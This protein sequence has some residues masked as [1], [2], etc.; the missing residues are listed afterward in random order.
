MCAGGT[1]ANMSAP[2]AQLV[3]AVVHFPVGGGRVLRA[4]DGVDLAIPEGAA[5]GLVGES[6]SGKST[7]GRALLGLQPLTSGQVRFAGA[8]VAGLRAASLRRI[9]RQMQPVFQDPRASLDPRLTVAASIAEPLRTHRLA[10]RAGVGRRVAELLITVGLDESHGARRPGRLS[11]G[12]LQRVAIA[13]ALA[14][15]PRLLVLD[16]PISALDVSVAAQILNLLADI[17]RERGLGYLLIAHDLPAV[18]HV[19]DTVVVLYLGR[20]VEQGPAA[21]VLDAPRHPYTRALVASVPRPPG[22]A[23]VD[24]LRLTGEP[25]SPIAPPPGCPLHPR[26]P[27]ARPVCAGTRPELRACGV[28]RLAACHIDDDQPL[29]RVGGEGGG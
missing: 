17:R 20:V 11:G 29:H 7:A 18:A 25:P 8:P 5:V 13:R 2:L 23:S 15:E 19:C 12:Q 3:G 9:R 27:L 24:D 22:A 21:L 4:L 28:G 16:E 6:G 26:C 10:S 1:M 14:C